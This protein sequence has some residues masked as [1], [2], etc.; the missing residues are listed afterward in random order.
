MFGQAPY[1]LNGMLNYN[2]DSLGLAA[3]ISYNRQGRRLVIAN[4]FT[5]P[6][7]YEIPRD[8]VDIKISKNLGKHFIV[9]F[10]IRDLL[11]S[12]IVR[13]YNFD[14]GEPIDFDRFRYGTIYQFGIQYKL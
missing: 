8:L 14:K 13:T 11:N 4:G 10:T 7:V 5:I 3:T 1:V 2:S 12:P 6:D 9:S